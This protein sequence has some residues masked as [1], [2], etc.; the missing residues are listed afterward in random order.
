[1][2]DYFLDTNI[3][4][5]ALERREK[6]EIARR[7]YES[8]ATRVSVQC[9]NE[10]ANTA[11]RKL[12]MEWPEIDRALADV[13]RRCAPIIPLNETLHVQGIRLA[14]RYGLSVYDGMIVAAGL[15]ARCDVLYSEDMHAGLLINGRLRIV[16][17]FAPA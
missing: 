10:L 11:R 12:K 6:G 16:N 4:V 8:G 13:R 5:Y 15:S 17:P 2:S 3:L 1:M 7:I 14:N 9:L